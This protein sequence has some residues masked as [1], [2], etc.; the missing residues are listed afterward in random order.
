MKWFM[1]IWLAM[2]CGIPTVFFVMGI[3]MI[4]SQKQKIDTFVPVDAVV[5]LTD[6]KE[7][8]STDSDGHSSTSYRPVINYS[9]TVNA[10]KYESNNVNPL[11]KIAASRSW[12]K[13]VVQQYPKEKQIT[14]Y[15]NPDRP[16]DAFLVCDLEYEP[17]LFAQFPM[18]FWMI[19]AVVWTYAGGRGKRVR[20]PEPKDEGGFILRPKRSLAKRRWTLLTM[21]AIWYALGTL[22]AGHYLV[23]ATNYS[24]TMYVVLPILTAIGFIPAGLLLYN[25]LLSRTVGEPLVM[26]DSNQFRL[27]GPF[28][29]LVA[30]PIK[31]AVTINELKVGLKC[32]QTTRTKSGGETKYS[33]NNCYEDNVTLSEDR[34]VREGEAVSGTNTFA[35]PADQSATNSDGY[36]MHD[37]YLEVKLDIAGSPNY[38]GR[39]PI[40]VEG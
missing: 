12:A 29:V 27:D 8:T 17:Y 35:I 18:L 1:R 2:F 16:D 3:F 36:P 11:G 28:S 7:V 22:T 26:I 5:L 23:Y 21:T 6:I 9:Y 34:E 30:L 39:F 40:R 20:P 15:Y 25:L 38:R 33:T 10:E 32:D 19:G 37:W 31:S 14:A 24:T 13:S 4:L